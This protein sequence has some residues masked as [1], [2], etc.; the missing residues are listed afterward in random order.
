MDL[1]KM[2]LREVMDEYR[3]KSHHFGAIEVMFWKIIMELEDIRTEL[4][5]NKEPD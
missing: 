1:D 2:T 5:I 3:K 4:S